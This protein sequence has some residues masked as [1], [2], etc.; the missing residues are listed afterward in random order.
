MDYKS[1]KFLLS[2]CDG[3]GRNWKRIAVLSAFI[4]FDRL[5]FRCYKRYGALN[6]DA[7]SKSIFQ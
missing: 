3:V 4:G 6:I 5:A 1:F 7:I 2:T